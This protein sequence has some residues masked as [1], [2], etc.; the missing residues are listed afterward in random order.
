MMFFG[1]YDEKIRKNPWLSGARAP[2]RYTILANSLTAGIKQNREYLCDDIFVLFIPSFY[3][4][5][6][7]RQK[8]E[9]KDTVSES[10]F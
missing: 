8:G 2:F 3:N 4:V 7:M 5:E 1:T 9:V 6:D 10:H